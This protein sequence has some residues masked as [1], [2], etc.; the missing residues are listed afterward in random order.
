[1][2]N[3]IPLILI[4]IC[5]TIIIIIS[6]RK[7]SI[8]VNIDVENIPKEKEAKMK[9]EILGNRLKRNLT[10]WSSKIFVFLK[11]IFDKL[12]FLF[13]WLYKKL[14]DARESY[15]KQEKIEKQDKEVVVKYSFEEIED[16]IKN[17]DYQTAEK[18]LID[19]I[20]LDSQ[21]SKAFEM[22]GE[23]YFAQKNYED[24][25]ETYNHLIKLL[26]HADDEEA[27]AEAYFE[28][29]LIDRELEDSESACRNLKKALKLNSNNPRYLD[30]ML[31][32]SIIN[33]DK[34][35]AL[36]AYERLEKANPENQKLDDFKKQIR[37]L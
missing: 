12:N 15:Q 8:L 35:S 13:K 28:I 20:G 37:E 27:L 25:R 31:E 6:V 29:S 7:F 16:L 5:L 2:Y 24:A 3:I 22:L 36:D 19:L 18:K 23:V 9:E 1:M 10:K 4:L 34:I 30:T 26:E 32:I 11:F 21:N 14:H 17:E 33:K